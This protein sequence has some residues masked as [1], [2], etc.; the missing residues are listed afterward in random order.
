[1]KSVE[2]IDKILALN[3]YDDESRES[4][5]DIL[6]QLYNKATPEQK[7]AMD[8]VTICIC[9]YSIKTILKQGRKLVKHAKLTSFVGMAGF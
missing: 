6:V 5:S 2:L 8:N 3:H 4:Q 9:G 7:E 1:M